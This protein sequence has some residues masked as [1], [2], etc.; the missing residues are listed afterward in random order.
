VRL[1]FSSMMIPDISKTNKIIKILKA[2]IPDKTII[3]LGAGSS[4]SPHLL[5]Y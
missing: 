5:Q 1:D 3:A 2:L 4:L